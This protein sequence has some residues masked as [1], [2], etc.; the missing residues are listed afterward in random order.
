MLTQKKVPFSKAQQLPIAEF[1]LAAIH[2][3]A[4]S[5]AQ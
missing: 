4:S 1:L 3:I 2:L 5:S